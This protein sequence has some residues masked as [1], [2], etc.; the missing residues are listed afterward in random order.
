M[1]ITATSI[2]LAISAVLSTG[3]SSMPAAPT[4][5]IISAPPQTVKEYV[6]TY[7]GAQGESV[8]EAIAGCESQYRQF[9]TDGTVYRGE[10][11]HQDV[12]VMQINEHYHL[13]EAQALGYDL[14]TEAGNVAFAQYLYEKQGT[15]P[16][17]SSSSCWDATKGADKATLALASTK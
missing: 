6:E 10:Q 12:G 15:A 1:S 2:A 9:D 16:W 14:Y 11:N 17:S 8:M 7:F 4:P 13:K 3:A 5:A